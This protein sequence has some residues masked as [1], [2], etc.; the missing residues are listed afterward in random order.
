MVCMNKTL[1]YIQILIL[2]CSMLCG[3]GFTGNL[4]QKSQAS[5]CAEHQ[6][7]CESES[8]CRK[9]CCCNSYERQDIGSKQ[10][11]GFHVFISSIKCKYGNNPL[12]AITFTAKYIGEDQIEFI[13]ASFLCFLLSYAAPY[14]S[15]TIASPPEKP[16]RYFI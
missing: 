1:S 6:C 3:G 13:K 9:H 10:K 4:P 14:P 15:E 7:G 8:D 12:T 11:N 5:L 16:P 2:I